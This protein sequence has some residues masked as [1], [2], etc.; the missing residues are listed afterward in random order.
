MVFSALLAI[1]LVL[2]VVILVH[3][4][5]H[6]VAARVTGIKVISL[7]IGIGPKLITK[8]IGDT[9]Y[10][11]AALPLGGYVRPLYRRKDSENILQSTIN[12]K[13]TGSLVKMFF[14][15]S[16]VE[17]ELIKSYSAEDPGNF[18]NASKP[19][20]IFF[21]LS[22]I[23]FNII[24]SM[25]ILTF[26]V[27]KTAPLTRMHNKPYVGTVT[28]NS[29]AANQGLKPG[30]LLVKVEDSTINSWEELYANIKNSHKNE[31]KVTFLR[32]KPEIKEVTATFDSRSLIM[33]RKRF[34][35]FFIA[36]FSPASYKVKPTFLQSVRFGIINTFSLAKE[37]ILFQSKDK[38]NLPEYYSYSEPAAEIATDPGLG[39]ISG[40]YNAGKESLK[41]SY[42]FMTMF[43][44]FSIIAALVNLV[45]YPACDGGQIAIIL[46]E[47]LNGKEVD[48]VFRERLAV[49]GIGSTVVI[50]ALS[51]GV[52]LLNFSR[53]VTSW[54]H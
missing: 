5:G 29:A 38:K 20:K 10:S 15:P 13:V 28:E 14:S 7:C 50:L 35:T 44:A 33:Q 46:V 8:R 12:P 53:I 41:T 21:Y 39:L 34:E 1:I 47:A 52:D 36:G 16:N 30:D 24:L 3:E 17:E 31:V 45:P 54:F 42:D 40:A 18:L 22:G 25:V 4:L 19:A 23:I 11:I 27:Y 48:M 2:L 51:L 49:F 43:F 26:Q 9:F 32:K 6:Y 37:L